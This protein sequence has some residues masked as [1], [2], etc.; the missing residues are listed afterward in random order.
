MAQ[1][2]GLD[3][4]VKSRPRPMADC[5]RARREFRQAHRCIGQDYLDLY[6]AH[7]PAKP[8]VVVTTVDWWEGPQSPMTSLFGFLNLSLASLERIADPATIVLIGNLPG[9]VPAA[10]REIHA[11]LLHA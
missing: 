10:M 1:K 7:I 6:T 9:G 11:Q 4:L 8:N 2:A 5:C 3:F